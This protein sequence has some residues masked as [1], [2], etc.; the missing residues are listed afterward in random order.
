MASPH[1]R[2]RP[3]WFAGHGATPGDS[4][5][6]PLAPG[7]D[8]GPT[9]ERRGR[10]RARTART[11][12]E[13]ARAESPALRRAREAA[14]RL[15]GCSGC[16][17]ETRPGPRYWTLW[18]MTITIESSRKSW[19]GPA[20]PPV[21]GLGARDREVDDAVE[22]DRAGEVGTNR[23]GYARSRRAPGAPSTTAEDPASQGPRGATAA[24]ACPRARGSAGG[25]PHAARAPADGSRRK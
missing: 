9:G 7:K 25:K 13:R 17:C 21:D 19:S 1:H 16:G 2:H 24:A 15:S 4:R 8:P 10:P 11:R 20:R 5:G 23:V 12:R 22:D 18:K 6:E 14:G 3:I